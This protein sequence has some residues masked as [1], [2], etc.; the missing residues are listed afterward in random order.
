MDRE[1]VI[2]AIE[3]GKVTQLYGVG[4]LAAALKVPHGYVTPLLNTGLFCHTHQWGK[5]RL[6][7]RERLDQIVCEH[8]SLIRA[9]SFLTGELPAGH[10]D[11]SLPTESTPDE[12]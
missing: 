6:F 8:G 3:V 4:D 5:C 2:R 12:I 9:G 10:S 1:Q 7:T 11:L